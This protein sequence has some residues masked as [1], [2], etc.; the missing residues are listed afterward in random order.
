MARTMFDDP[1]KF[2]DNDLLKGRRKEEE[3]S[4]AEHAKILLAAQNWTAN[5]MQQIPSEPTGGFM[6]IKQPY[7]GRCAILLLAHVRPWGLPMIAPD[8]V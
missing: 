8:H 4:D 6:V 5:N 1:A 3:I 2:E 7:I